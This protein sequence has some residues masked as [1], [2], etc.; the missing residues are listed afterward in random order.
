[1][2]EFFVADAEKRRIAELI[3]DDGAC[4]IIDYEPFYSVA[5]AGASPPEWGNSVLLLQN[6]PWKKTTREDGS[7]VICLLVHANES[8]IQTRRKWFGL[9]ADEAAAFY[10]QIPDRVNCTSVLN[11]SDSSEL[12]RDQLPLTGVGGL[13]LDRSSVAIAPFLWWAIRCHITSP[14]CRLGAKSR[15]RRTRR[16]A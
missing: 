5:D 6:G 4:P 15:S 8:F 14:Q 9:T 10:E 2:Q 1:M 13:Q 12:G 3:D 7:V 11:G 16:H